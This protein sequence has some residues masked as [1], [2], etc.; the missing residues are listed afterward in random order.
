MKERLVGGTVLVVIAAWLVPWVLDG[1]EGGAEAPESTLQ[2][3]SAEEPMPMRT[4]TLKLGDAPEPSAEPAATPSATPPAAQAAAA[5]GP[6]KPAAESR[7][8]AGTDARG[9]ATQG[10]VTEPKPEAESTRVAA[11]LVAESP[12]TAPAAAPPPKPQAAVAGDWTVQLGS[13]ED[14]ANARRLAQRA[15]TFGH[16]AEVSSYKSGARTLYRVRVGPQATKAAADAAA[17]ALRAH[18]VEARV[19]AAR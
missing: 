19:V 14:E 4:Q 13:F 6:A 2:L 17:S 5:T 12:K 7:E 11:N 9:R 3:P 18:G 16:K 8:D 1:P 15:G 10:A